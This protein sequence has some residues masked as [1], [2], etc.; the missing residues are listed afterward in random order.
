MEPSNRLARN[1]VME[2]KAYGYTLTIWGGGAI[3]IAHYG[4]PNIARVALYAGGALVAM[5]AL[6]FAAFGG[7]FTEQ[8]QPETDPRLAASMIHFAA[9][10]GSLVVSYLAV[11]VGRPLV[12][13][14]IV[15]VI[16]GFLTTF[17]YNIGL[18]FEDV[19]ARFLS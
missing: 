11:V 2:S 16:V 17:V 15:F 19:V 6:A 10:G 1:L 7:M 18:I 14:N 5:G 4:T 9:T 13:P 12:S 3:L 8:H